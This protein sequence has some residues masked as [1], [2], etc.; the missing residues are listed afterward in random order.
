[1]Q[2]TRFGPGGEFGH[3]VELA[4]ELADELAGVVALTEL[5]DLLED[6]RERIFGLRD[7]AFRV[8]LTL[9]FEALMMFEELFAE[10]LG[11]ALTG[12]TGQGSWLT[13]GVDGRQTTL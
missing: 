5:L 9:T 13:W 8:V 1:M 7:R 4:K 3:D 11:E 6:S 12:S 2:L 10:E